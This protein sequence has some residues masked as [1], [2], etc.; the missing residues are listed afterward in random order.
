MI[1]FYSRFLMKKTHWILL[2]VDILVLWAFLKARPA[3]MLFSPTGAP[4]AAAVFVALISLLWI[5]ARSV[6]LAAM[7]RE[8]KKS[9]ACW[10]AALAVVPVALIAAAALVYTTYFSVRTELREAELEKRNIR[11]PAGYEGYLAIYNPGG[12]TSRNACAFPAAVPDPGFYEIP[13]GCSQEDFAAR[14]S[15]SNSRIDF[16]APDRREAL[17]NSKDSI[18]GQG[19]I[20]IYFVESEMHHQQSPIAS[21]SDFSLRKTVLGFKR[22]RAENPALRF[23]DFFAA[24]SLRCQR[25]MGDAQEKISVRRLE[26]TGSLADAVAAFDAEPA[27]LSAWV[28]ASIVRSVLRNLTRNPQ[29]PREWDVLKKRRGDF[30]SFIDQNLWIGV[31]TMG[32][33]V[34]A[35]LCRTFPSLPKSDCDPDRKANNPEGREPF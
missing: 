13:G 14:F 5:F 35:V 15:L 10:L 4:G 31:E 20:V 26:S 18:N 21:L 34:P 9:A 12:E 6:Y 32:R 33:P 8:T 25:T 17:W 19:F 30:V 28:E 23:N 1:W 3:D 16:S 22:A 29:A 27:C 7:F 24:C 2:P 11:V